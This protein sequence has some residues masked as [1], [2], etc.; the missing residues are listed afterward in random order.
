[1]AVLMGISNA[2][3]IL[4]CNA[5][6][7]TLDGAGSTIKIYDGTRATDVDTALGAQVL[8]GTLTAATPMF[9][10]AVD[11][12]PGARATANAIT[13]DASADATSTATWFRVATSA[14]S[15]KFDGNVGTAT[16]DMIL[17]TVAIVT[18]AEIAITSYTVTQPES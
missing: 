17:N 3:A 2:V 6:V 9:G 12:S 1:M 11:I 5:A 4:M 10:A 14:A 7:D 15:N 16:A 18:G 8:L 13:S